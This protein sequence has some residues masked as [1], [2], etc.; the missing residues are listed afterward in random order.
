MFARWL[1]FRRTGPYIED[2]AKSLI[3]GLIREDRLESEGSEIRRRG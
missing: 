2:A 3:N 1:G